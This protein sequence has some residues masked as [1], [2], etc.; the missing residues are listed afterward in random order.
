[1]NGRLS[2]L[3]LIQEMSAHLADVARLDADAH[4]FDQ[5]GAMSLD[6]LRQL[7]EMR[8]KSLLASRQCA[9]SQRE[10]G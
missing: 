2:R 3:E 6:I 5:E 1:M 7:V 10:E 9:K 8:Y 4:V